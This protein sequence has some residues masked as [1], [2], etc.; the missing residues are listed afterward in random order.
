MCQTLC[1]MLGVQGEARQVQSCSHRV[2]SP[3]EHSGKDGI[4]SYILLP[5]G[6]VQSNLSGST[7]GRHLTQTRSTGLVEGFLEDNVMP[8]LRLDG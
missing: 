8:Q 4:A 6:K 1:Q 7:C 3:A 2:S 5:A